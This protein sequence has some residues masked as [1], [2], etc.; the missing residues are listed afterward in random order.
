MLWFAYTW[1]EQNPKESFTDILDQRVDIFRRTQLHP[2]EI[3]DLQ[4]LDSNQNWQNLKKS[5]IE[6]FHQ[7]PNAATFEKETLPLF[8]SL[9]EGRVIRDLDDLH[10]G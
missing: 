10:E 6:I 5:L 8:D 7:S 1:K 9:L 4:D 3:F 2:G